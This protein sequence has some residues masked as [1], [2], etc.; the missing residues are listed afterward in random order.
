[1]L[2]NV[3]S[4]IRGWTP[5]IS[6]LTSWPHE[7]PRSALYSQCYNCRLRLDT[8]ETRLV[9]TRKPQCE[10]G[11]DGRERRVTIP[12]LQLLSL[13]VVI[14]C[15]RHSSGQRSPSTHSHTHTHTNASTRNKFNFLP[16]LNLSPASRDTSK[17]AILVFAIHALTIVPHTHTHTHTHA[18]APT[19]PLWPRFLYRVA[20][21]QREK[22]DRLKMASDVFN[23]VV[24]YGGMHSQ[25]S[26]PPPRV[27]IIHEDAG[28]W[29]QRA[30]I[31]RKVPFETPGKSISTTPIDS[32]ELYSVFNASYMD[33]GK[34]YAYYIPQIFG[35]CYKK[36]Y[37]WL[38]QWLL[39]FPTAWFPGSIRQQVDVKGLWQRIL[40][41][42]FCNT[43]KEGTRL[44]STGRALK[45]CSSPVRLSPHSVPRAGRNKTSLLSRITLLPLTQMLVKRYVL[46]IDQVV[47]PIEWGFR[48]KYRDHLAAY[49]CRPSITTS[50]PNGQASKHTSAGYCPVMHECANQAVASDKT[51]KLLAGVGIDGENGVACRRKF[52]SHETPCLT[53]IKNNSPL[54]SAVTFNQRTGVRVPTGS[55]PD[56]HTCGTRAGRCCWSASFLGNLPFFPRP[57]ILALFHTHLALPASSLKT[58]ILRA[59]QISSLTHSLTNILVSDW[60]SSL[61][62]ARGNR[63]APSSHA[64]CPNL[65]WPYVTIQWMAVGQNSCRY[66]HLVRGGGCVGGQR[67]STLQSANGGFVEAPADLPSRVRGIWGNYATRN[68]ITLGITLYGVGL[69]ASLSKDP[70]RDEA[71]KMQLGV[72]LFAFRHNNQPTATVSFSNQRA[73]DI[74]TIAHKT[75]ESSLEDVSK[76][77][78]ISQR[79]NGLEATVAERLDCSP[80]TGFDP[81][82]V[83]FGFSQLGIMPGLFRWSGGFLGVLRL[84]LPLHSDAAPFS[85]RFT[86]AV[87][88]LPNLS[89]SL[90]FPNINLFVRVEEVIGNHTVAVREPS[91]LFARRDRAVIYGAASLGLW[92]PQI[93]FSLTRAS[94]DYNQS[95]LGTSAQDISE[96]GSDIHLHLT[97]CPLREPWRAGIAQMVHTSRHPLPL[98]MSWDDKSTTLCHAAIRADRSGM[99]TRWPGARIETKAKRSRQQKTKLRGLISRATL[100][101]QP[102]TLSARQRLPVRD[103]TS[104]LARN[105]QQTLSR[106]SKLGFTLPLRMDTSQ[107]V[108]AGGKFTHGGKVCWVGNG[109]ANVSAVFRQARPQKQ[110][111]AVGVIMASVLGPFPLPPGARSMKLITA[112]ENLL[113]KQPP[114]GGGGSGRQEKKRMGGGEG[115]TCRQAAVARNPPLAMFSTRELA[116]F[117]HA[118]ICTLRGMGCA[119]EYEN[120]ALSSTSSLIDGRKGRTTYARAPNVGYDPT[121][122]R[123]KDHLSKCPPPPPGQHITDPARG[124]SDPRVRDQRPRYEGSV[125][126]GQKRGRGQ[127]SRTYDL[128][129]KNPNQTYKE[130]ASVLARNGNETI[131]E[132]TMSC[133]V[134]G[135]EATTSGMTE[136]SPR[137]CELQSSG[138]SDRIRV[139][140]GGR[141]L[142]RATVISDAEITLLAR[143]CVLCAC[144]HVL[145]A[146]AC[147]EDDR[148]V[149]LIFSPQC[150]HDEH[151]I[152]HAKLY[153]IRPVPFCGGITGLTS[154]SCTVGQDTSGPITQCLKSVP[155]MSIRARAAPNLG[156]RVS[157][158]HLKN[159]LDYYPSL[160]QPDS[161]CGEP[162]R[163]RPA[164]IK[165]A[166]G[167]RVERAAR[168]VT[169]VREICDCEH[170][171]SEGCDWQAGL[172]GL[173]QFQAWRGPY[174]K[175]LA[176]R[177]AEKLLVLYAKKK[178]LR[179]TG[180]FELLALGSQL[181]GV[182]L[183]ALVAL[184]VGIS[185]PNTKCGVKRHTVGT[186]YR[187]TGTDL[188]CYGCPWESCN[189]SRAMD[190][191]YLC[192]VGVRSTDQHTSAVPSMTAAR[193]V[194]DARGETSPASPLHPPP[195]LVDTMITETPAKHDA[196]QGPY[197]GDPIK[198]RIQ[199]FFFPKAEFKSAYFIVNKKTRR[200]LSRMHGIAEEA[201]CGTHRADE[202]KVRWIWSSAGMKWQGETRYSRENPPTRGNVHRIYHMRKSD[203][204]S[205]GLLWGIS[206]LNNPPS[207]P[208]RD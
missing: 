52:S 63:R 23:G 127:K 62:E 61:K 129:P 116:I 5:A 13:T 34:N 163:A 178:K 19:P 35:E 78:I 28:T 42:K 2:R 130:S 105:V 188:S 38:T 201:V 67:V 120:R 136:Y 113:L 25:K 126:Q 197:Y 176:H 175:I 96:R 39:K 57:F 37:L 132:E 40:P 29:L 200:I 22:G 203:V 43:L 142:G 138:E 56:I 135:L 153:V 83:H 174:T 148:S 125:T 36:V 101:A 8:H 75:V 54:Q 207:S 98:Q 10:R 172:L 32:P 66:S 60:G 170:Q 94:G 161:G 100:R 159:G 11:C 195:P 137:L 167:R 151:F 147:A 171:R 59:A 145:V 53:F 157:L 3:T 177:A 44:P 18:P 109:G 150:R 117:G 72:P 114:G 90:V 85:P 121:S 190:M 198:I 149:Y 165:I 31:A 183:P 6:S 15:P 41:G 70:R 154:K 106:D 51:G 166:N 196:T 194:G 91:G 180:I 103:N 95:D 179:A 50:A 110:R 155:V 112:G 58:S 55:L 144:A 123:N 186:E 17:Y 27:C 206:V 1:M 134:R 202:S 118:G 87:K 124:I 104:R 46:Q 164:A 20:S 93:N 88:S 141:M 64:K 193:Q 81:R 45:L 86:H 128:Y 48:G 89:T 204:I 99:E 181:L 158:R 173:Q 168:E 185:L 26:P 21:G 162:S 133:A 184:A 84:P 33:K 73:I 208:L 97:S 199:Y 108:Y 115:R 169:R 92:W 65:S 76:C 146:G 156:Y 47:S 139:H 69:S 79:R 189:S 143:V 14:V 102:P 192:Y 182:E 140:T 82:A 107:L 119:L 187:V 74:C 24:A 160:S 205:P 68:H 12:E 30:R 49:N 16:P 122:K 191:A 131:R 9:S 111:V 152:R 77:L 71:I 7:N 4:Q 80:R